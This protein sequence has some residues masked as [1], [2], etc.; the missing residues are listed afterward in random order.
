ML[1]HASIWKAIDALASRHDISPSGL[2]KL[3]GLDPTTFNPSKRFKPNGKPR[4]PSTESIA[5]ILDVTQSTPD[6]FFSQNFERVSSRQVP[7]PERKAF[8]LP[9][10]AGD[11]PNAGVE[12]DTLPCP[13]STVPLWLEEKSAGTFFEN[14]ALEETEQVDNRDIEKIRHSA[15]ETRQ[16]QDFISFPA[17]P[18]EPVFALPVCNDAFEPLYR[19]G[20][21][22]LVS[23]TASLRHGDRMIAK[24]HAGLLS[25]YSLIRTTARNLVVHSIQ[26]PNIETIV[27]LS[28][29]R[30][31]ARILWASQ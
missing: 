28:D 13:S 12:Q 11:G 10:G 22:L 14:V 7:A 2:A 19:C 9:E 26:E 8:L 24:S 1:S 31:S 20:D 27:A 5:K 6:W 17:E 30:W 23:P 3:A 15:S 29:L 16:L 21:T 25:V 18:H 4:W